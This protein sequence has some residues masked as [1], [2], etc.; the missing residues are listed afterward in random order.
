MTENIERKKY[1]NLDDSF[2][3]MWPYQ[4]NLFIFLIFGLEN[5]NS[6]HTKMAA[7]V[8]ILIKDYLTYMPMIR[9]K[10]FHLCTTGLFNLIIIIFHNKIDSNMRQAKI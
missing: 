8:L 7:I 9:I 3:Y 10:Y 4:P 1:M 6:N 5:Y 2:S